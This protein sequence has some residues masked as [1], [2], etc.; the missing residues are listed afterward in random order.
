MQLTGFDLADYERLLDAALERGWRFL[1][2]EEY[3]RADDPDAP[4][5]VLR[6]DV[7]RKVGSA[8]AMAEAEAERGVQATYYFRT[9]TFD[10]E[11]ATAMAERGHEVGYHYED[12]AATRGDVAAARDRFV[13]NLERFR[14][15]VDVTT[16]CAHGSPLSPHVNTAMWDDDPAFEEYGLLGEAYLSIDFEDERH[17]GEEPLAYLSD[18]GRDWDLD[19]PGFGRVRSTDDVIDAFR[20]HARQRFYVLAHPC[21]WSKSRAEFLERSGWDVA[22]ETVKS[23]VEQAHRLQ[24]A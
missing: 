21:R 15:H 16:A 3:L 10:P 1:T 17:A 5:V 11:T 7:D 2:V 22:T 19:L 9:G 13:R 6:H 23:V 18:T 24:R 12:L 4:F 20:G 14:R 8:V